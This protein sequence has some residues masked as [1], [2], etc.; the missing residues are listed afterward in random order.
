MAYT[1]QVDVAIIGAGPAGLFAGSLLPTV[2]ST[3]IVER[4]SREF[5]KPCGGLL[6]DGGLEYLLPFE[7]PDWIYASPRRI[8]TRLVDLENQEEHTTARENNNLRRGRLERWLRSLLNRSTIFY[9]HTAVESIRTR[10]GRYE[11]VLAHDHGGR[12]LLRASIILGS[13][14]VRS[15]IRA[16]L[17][18]SPANSVPTVQY[19]LPNRRGMAH[20]ELLFHSSTTG[21]F[22]IW[23][24]P[25]DQWLL[26]GTRHD[27]EQRKRFDEVIRSRYGVEP[28]QE[29]SDRQGYPLTRVGGK[30][31]IAFGRDRI[32]LLGEAAGLVLPAFGEGLA[33]ALES[34]YRACMAIRASFE[35]PLPR[36]RGECASLLARIE[37]EASI[38]PLMASAS[39]RHLAFHI[40]TDP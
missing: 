16:L 37:Q 8:G 20:T 28:P 18:L 14:G 31:E 5:V 15:E 38:Y 34:A 33:P 2:Y 6:D 32:L 36:Y 11:I 13:D 29:I 3:A 21:S 9:E 12:S 1:E 22:H 4:R 40:L 10:H 7:P 25:K 24:I 35:D 19:R 17:G 27:L 30:D 23:A 39:T 26:V